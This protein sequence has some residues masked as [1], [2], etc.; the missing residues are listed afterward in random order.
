LDGVAHA[1]ESRRL[2][3]HLSAC[4]FEEQEKDPPKPLEEGAKQIISLVSALFSVVSG[5]WRWRILHCWRI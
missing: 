4:W 3:R 5:F 1:I 2:V